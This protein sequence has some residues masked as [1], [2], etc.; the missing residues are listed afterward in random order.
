MLKDKIISTFAPI[1][2]NQFFLN[3]I[4]TVSNFDLDSENKIVAFTI[5]LKGEEKPVDIKANFKIENRDNENYFVV[6]NVKASREWIVEA[7]KIL[8]KENKEIKLPASAE[9]VLKFLM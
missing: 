4:G 8:P 2:A 9:M 5:L 3:K 6:E 7:A 1:F